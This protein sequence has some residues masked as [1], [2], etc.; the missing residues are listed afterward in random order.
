MQI[1]VNIETLLDRMEEAPKNVRFKELVKVCDH[2]FGEPRQN[3]TSHKIYKT[4]WRDDPRVNIQKQSKGDKAKPYQVKQVLK[5]IEKL[6][7]EKKT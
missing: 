6:S 2:F 3:G 4:P 5:A 7:E 1:M